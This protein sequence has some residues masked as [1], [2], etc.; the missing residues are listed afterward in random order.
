MTNG[1]GRAGSGTG[2][3]PTMTGARVSVVIPVYNGVEHCVG[4]VASVLD[5]TRP[6][7]EVIV[8]DD[9]S[10]DLGS[11]AILAYLAERR[12]PVPVKVERRTNQGQSAAR[13]A[14]VRLTTGELVA[15]CDQDDRWTPS[16]LEVLAGHLESAPSDVAWV[17][18]DFDEV[19]AAGRLVT[20]GYRAR[21]GVASDPQSVDQVIAHDLMVLPSA[22]VV[23]R[24][25]FDAVGG[26][27]PELSGY[28]DDD[29][30]LRMFRAGYRIVGVPHALTIYRVHPA[31][32]SASPAFQRSRVRFLAKIR[33]SLP[34]HVR[35]N[36]Y[37]VHD[38][39]YPRLHE[40]TLLEYAAMLRA[41]DRAATVALGVTA[42]ELARVAGATGRRRRLAC[43]ALRHP[44]AL[45]V[46][47]VGLRCVPPPLRPRAGPGVRAV[48]AAL[49]VRCR[50][51]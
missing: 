27:D 26:F 12:S 49:G 1:P 19:D 32:S 11:E 36:R 4:A 33:E 48:L 51:A 41:G 46:S 34:D 30:Y 24:S 31:G 6:P 10:D 47:A 7:D 15:F 28:E 25:A 38:V 37:W 17:Y 45:R 20:R 23:R 21:H 39:C 43:W 5:Q 13:N 29:L 2:S 8:V 44:R 42:T 50:P 3:L 14:G 18:S 35:S 40:A 16:H 22:S 9:G